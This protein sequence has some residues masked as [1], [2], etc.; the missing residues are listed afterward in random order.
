MTSQEDPI[1]DELEQAAAEIEGTEAAKAGPLWGAVHKLMLKSSLDRAEAARIVMRRDLQGLRKLIRSTHDDDASTEQPP[2][3]EAS[4]E[5]AAQKHNVSPET[6]RKAMRAFRKRLK[7]TRLDH[8]SKLGVGPM[9]GGRKASFDAI[10]PPH[11]FPR[12][13]WQALVAAGR[14]RDV[15]QGFY[16]LVEE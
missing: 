7:L 8:E 2:A 4:L 1:L 5:E 13:V 14:L 6:M 3:E 11:E 16:M 9:T 15:G 12:E 10:L